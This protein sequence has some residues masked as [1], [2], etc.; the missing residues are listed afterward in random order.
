MIRSPESC[1]CCPEDKA[2][3]HEAA[4][5]QADFT[6]EQLRALSGAV[7]QALQLTRP[8][9]SSTG[10]A[11]RSRLPLTQASC[12]LRTR[13]RVPLSLICWADGLT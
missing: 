11:P 5:K 8:S 3:R 7:G 1:D 13:A 10:F 6:S 9:T 4:R 2:S 12:T